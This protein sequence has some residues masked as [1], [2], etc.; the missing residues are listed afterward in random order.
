VFSDDYLIKRWHVPHQ[1]TGENIKAALEGIQNFDTGGVTSPISF[2]ATSHRGSNS[3][4]LYQVQ[5]GAW[6]SISDFI[7]AE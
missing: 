7:S 1:W 6:T 2:S 3:L 4:R 5:G